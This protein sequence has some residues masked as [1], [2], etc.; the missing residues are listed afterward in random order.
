MLN[1][2]RT[3]ASAVNSQDYLVRWRQATTDG[4]DAFSSG[5]YREA[6]V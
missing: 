2:I 1:E 4:N 3:E 6:I 5:S